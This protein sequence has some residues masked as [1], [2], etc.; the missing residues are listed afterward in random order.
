MIPSYS[1]FCGLSDKEALRQ[2]CSNGMGY[3]PGGGNGGTVT[4]ATSKSTGVTLNRLSGQITLNNASLASGAKVSFV[5]TN[6]LVGVGDTPTVA[7]QSGGTANAYRADVTA[8]AA[9]SF[10][11]T[12]ENL[13]GGSLGEAP[14]IG[15]NVIKGTST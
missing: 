6:S 10:T 3:S 13:T 5:V 2:I 4:Q 14:V 11:I 9:G 1:Q 15:F 7:V 12:V 8:V